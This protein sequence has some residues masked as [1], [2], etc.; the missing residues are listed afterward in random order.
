M[1]SISTTNIDTKKIKD[2]LLFTTVYLSIIKQTFRN[3]RKGNYKS[4]NKN[5]GLLSPTIQGQTLGSESKFK[6]VSSIYF[7]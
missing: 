4:K 3:N 6:N 7:V 5:L 2:V 1:S